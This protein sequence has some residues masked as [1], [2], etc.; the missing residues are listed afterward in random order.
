MSAEFLEKSKR[1]PS[2]SDPIVLDGGLP[3]EEAVRSD[4]IMMTAQTEQGVEVARVETAQE[5]IA[6][7]DIERA[8][9]EKEQ[10]SRKKNGTNWPMIIAVGLG[11]GY[12]MR[13]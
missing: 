11:L 4:D 8:R 6:P 5:Q 9:I 13:H 3:T 2:N 7:D 12:L 1:T 10:S